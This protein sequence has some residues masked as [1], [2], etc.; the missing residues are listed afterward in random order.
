MGDLLG[1]LIGG[2]ASPQSSSESGG[3]G[4]LLGGLLGGGGQ[5]A[6]G[7]GGL[8]GGLLG[9]GSSQQTFGGGGGVSMPFASTLAEKLGISEQMASML[10]MGAIGLLTSSLAKKRSSGRGGEVAFNEVTD[11]DYIR[12]SGIASQLSSQMGI[13]EDE[14]VYGLQQTMNLMA[15]GAPP[16]PQAKKTTQKSTAKKSTSK[17]TKTSAKKKSSG[18]KSES[19]FQNLLDD[20]TN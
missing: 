11:A 15:A 20:M 18:K 13:S 17:S 3:L 2:G 1:S 12:S 10:I 14:A 19:D 8:L 9:G 7:L 4:D 16:E 5:S 6:G